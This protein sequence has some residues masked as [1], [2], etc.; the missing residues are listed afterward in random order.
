MNDKVAILTD[1]KIYTL[2]CGLCYDAL[3]HRGMV[4]T[5]PPAANVHHFNNRYV[6]GRTVE[7]YT[8]RM[9]AE[10]IDHSLHV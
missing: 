6:V 9:V 1:G 2:M 3:L 7:G 8:L 5:M 4:E 10:H